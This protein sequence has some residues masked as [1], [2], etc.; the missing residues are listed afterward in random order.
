MSATTRHRPHASAPGA[1]IVRRVT[2][3]ALLSVAIVTLLLAVPGLQ[4]VAGQISRMDAGWVIAAV[5]LE[6]GSCAAFR[7]GVPVV[8]R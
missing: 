2:I 4:G 1:Q 6:L 7:R 3:V 5:A 8:F